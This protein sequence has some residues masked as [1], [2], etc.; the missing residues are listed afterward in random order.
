MDGQKAATVTATGSVLTTLWGYGETVLFLALG[1]FILIAFFHPALRRAAF[2]LIMAAL[3]ALVVGGLAQGQEIFH[4][5]AEDARAGFR[6]DHLAGTAWLLEVARAVATALARLAS[7]VLLGL[8]L[9]YTARHILYVPPDG[10]ATDAR[11]RQAWKDQPWSWRWPVVWWP[12]LAGVLPLLGVSYALLIYPRHGAGS[13][14][15][16]EEELAVAPWAQWLGALALG[17]ALFELL[18][19]PLL[20]GVGWSGVLRRLRRRERPQA[21]PVTALL[22]GGRQAGRR[23][24]ASTRHL[25]HTWLFLVVSSAVAVVVLVILWCSAAG[26]PQMLFTIPPHLLGL[27]TVLLAARWAWLRWR[28]AL[29]EPAPREPELG[30]DWPA[31]RGR[32]VLG[33]AALWLVAIAASYAADRTVPP[34]PGWIMALGSPVVFAAGWAALTLIGSL[35]SFW[36]ARDR[37]LKGGNVVAG[38]LVWTL[39]LTYLDLTDTHPVWT[40]PVDRPGDAKAAAD[41]RP[42]VEQHLAAW[43]LARR[44]ELP[45]GRQGEPVPLLVVAAHGGGLRAAYWT[46]LT[47]AGLEEAYPGFHRKVFAVTAVSGG[48]LGALLWHATLPRP[49]R[50]DLAVA[51]ATCEGSQADRLDKALGRDFLA[52]ELLGLIAVD[53]PARFYPDPR[54]VAW[55]RLILPDWAGTPD[56]QRFLE[57]G[58]LADSCLPLLGRNG[59]DGRPE[60]REFLRVVRPDPGDTDLPALFLVG[61]EVRTGDRA[62]V[63]DL[64]F[65]RNLIKGAMDVLAEGGCPD[66]ERPRA[67]EDCGLRLPAVAAAGLSAR[68]PWISPQA[69]LPGNAGILDGGLFEATGAETAAEL[70]R[71]L[72]A[73]CDPEAPEQATGLY[74]CTINTDPKWLTFCPSNERSKR[75]D[76][77]TGKSLVPVLVRPLALQLVNAPVEESRDGKPSRFAPETLGPVLTLA[78]TRGAR[79]RAAWRT[80][81]SDRQ[82]FNGSLRAT[83]KLEFEREGT[84]ASVPLSWT[85]SAAARGAMRGRVQRLLNLA[86]AD[87]ACDAAEAAGSGESRRDCAVV[88][89]LERDLGLV[90]VSDLREPPPSVDPARWRLAERFAGPALA[91]ACGINPAARRGSEL[92]R[93]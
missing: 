50:A 47:L 36:I 6:A 76:C 78:A 89:M 61:T 58:W 82:L 32:L 8:C 27:A 85:L 12:R 5:M 55:L 40:L 7:I 51:D 38:V 72:A 60:T 80:L 67:D 53:L 22:L 64:G 2:P 46:A 17:V 35:F 26:W 90:R 19:L 11:I 34:D 57:G 37:Q 86:E 48:S 1:A 69:R 74:Y 3:A 75:P 31:V 20:A 73:H 91:R 45:P 84:R 28:P 65:D 39:V 33:V 21:E 15:S 54:N 16:T 92:A 77:L 43:L 63:S 52:A 87:A 56:R 24:Q 42:K 25:E 14:P 88:C 70:Y 79:G 49:G 30:V 93:E 59:G 83:A 41:R 13:A 4:V 68:F 66:P 29:D 18:V 10:P 62:I 44:A 9:W 81:D 71:F 23:Y